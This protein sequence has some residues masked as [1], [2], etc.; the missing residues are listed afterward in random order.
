MRYLNITPEMVGDQRNRSSLVMIEATMLYPMDE[1][2]RQ[3]VMDA[4]HAAWERLEIRK[5]ARD[6]PETSLSAVEIANLVD[7]FADAP[8]LLPIQEEVKTAFQHG[9]VAGMLI[10]KA[11]HDGEKLGSIITELSKDLSNI[12]E[13]HVNN[14]IRP[15]FMSVCHYWAAYL[16]LGFD[17]D[18]MDFPCH[19][20]DLP[21]F[22]AIAEW[23]RTKGEAYFPRQSRKPLIDPNVSLKLPPNIQLPSLG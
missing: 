21:Y 8:P 7:K 4:G 1:I 15:E 6:A 10:R 17:C 2:A 12:S 16:H 20:R 3:K 5:L 22:L 9:V 13:S 19:I 18:K 14:N 23:Y 11:L